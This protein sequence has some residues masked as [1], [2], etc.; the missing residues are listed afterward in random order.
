MRPIRFHDLRHNIAIN[1]LI[2]GVSMEEVSAWVGHSSISTTEKGY[3]HITVAM[4]RRAAGVLDQ[5]MGYP[6][7]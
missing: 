3:A 4:R 1:L 6:L 2:M 7:S 5:F